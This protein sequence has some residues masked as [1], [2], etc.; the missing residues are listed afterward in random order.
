VFSRNGVAFELGASGDVERLGPPVLSS[1]LHRMA[2]HTGDGL[3]DSL[4]EDSRTK[5]LDPDLK[6]RK[7][8]L[9]KLWDAFERLKTIEGG[10][11]RT[12]VAALL[13]KGISGTE[14]RSRIEAEL[15]EL[16]AIGN[17]F[18]I[19]HSEVGKTPIGS[20]EQVDYLFHRMF[21]VIQLLLK[22]TKRGS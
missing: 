20:S 11:K 17:S 9:E 13:V 22:A 12:A 14:M 7:D 19:R 1:A 5:F 3:L 18:M 6:V 2:F 15:M 8:S 16:T 10:D 4:L 21:A